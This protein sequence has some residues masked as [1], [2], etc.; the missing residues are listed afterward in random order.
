LPPACPRLLRAGALCLALA[1]AAA[2]AG[3]AGAWPLDIKVLSYNVRGAVD[4]TRR[5]ALGEIGELI[6]QE[7]PDLVAVQ[8]LPHSLVE[9]LAREIGLPHHRAVPI[10]GPQPWRVQLGL[11]SRWPLE[12]GMLLLPGEKRRV[13]KAA[14]D[15]QGIPLALYG[16]HLPRRGLTSVKGLVLE[17]LG[18]GLR[19]EL[20]ESLVAD[21]KAEPRRFVVLAGDLNT[22]PLSGP[23]RLLAGV[24]DDAFPSLFADGTYRLEASGADL[25]AAVPNPKLDHIFHSPALAALSARVL[26]TGPS[27]HYPVVAILRLQV[28]DAVSGPDDIR[29]LQEALA[30]LGLLKGRATGEL[31]PP[32]RRALAAFQRDRGLPVDGLAGDR[33]W[34][35]LR[36]ARPR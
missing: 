13:A 8:E 16:V 34:G 36:E 5:Q 23:Y 33:T 6:R 28:R 1:A 25:P 4:D 7:S 15:L 19:A 10:Y 24:L 22:F 35:L 30:R 21:L 29:R 20:M 3:T 14:V 2:L 32:T 17:M 9:P 31:D 12:A 18:L 26:R 27:D 11:F